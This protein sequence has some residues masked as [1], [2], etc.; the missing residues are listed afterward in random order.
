MQTY[1]FFFTFNEFVITFLLQIRC[2]PKAKPY[3]VNMFL[4]LM[5]RYLF[6]T[7]AV[8]LSGEVSNVSTP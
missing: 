1:D 6:M 4:C 2:L 8:S 3:Y 7:S 5:S